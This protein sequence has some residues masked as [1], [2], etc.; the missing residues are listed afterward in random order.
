MGFGAGEVLIGEGQRVFISKSLAGDHSVDY[1][2]NQ[3]TIWQ[4]LWDVRLLLPNRERS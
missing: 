1:W 3:R 4:M 2:R